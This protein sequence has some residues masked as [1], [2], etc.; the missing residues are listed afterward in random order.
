M[1]KSPLLS[2]LTLGLF[3]LV[4]SA[5]A[6]NYTGEAWLDWTSLKCS[7]IPITM[8]A[9]NQTHNVFIHPNS[10]QSEFFEDWR[11]HITTLTV[12]QGATAVS[13]ADSSRLYASFG[14]FGSGAGNDSVERVGVFS[15][16]DTGN[17]T[18]SIDYTLRTIDVS[19]LQSNLYSWTG[20]GL[21]LYRENTTPIEDHGILN[22]SSRDSVLG[23]TLSVTQSYQRGAIGSFVATA[24]A[25]TD[26]RGSSVPLP[27]MLWPT[28]AGMIG[29]AF[30]AERRRQQARLTR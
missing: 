18:I 26:V 8:T 7:G 16:T 4:P 19:S 25:L 5:H 17:L 9:T 29:I 27:D 21:R 3:L 1:R 2:S 14:T 23:G 24:H 15:A 10:V 13:A 30:W 12:P 11:D 22:A 28:L 6:V 20:V